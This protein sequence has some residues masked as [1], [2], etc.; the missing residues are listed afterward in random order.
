MYLRE[1]CHTIQTTSSHPLSLYE[2]AG[3]SELNKL[4]ITSGRGIRTTLLG[5]LDPKAI[6]LPGSIPK[7]TVPITEKDLKKRRHDCYMT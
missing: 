1:L 3:D 2:G 5:L 7:E 4:H 6:I